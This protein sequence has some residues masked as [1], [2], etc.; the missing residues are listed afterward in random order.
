[1]KRIFF[2][3][4]LMLL[5]VWQAQAQTQVIDLRTGILNGSGTPG[6]KLSH[7]NYTKDDT[8]S[9]CYPGSNP[10]SPSS[11][12]DAYC[13]NGASYYGS[14][15]NT[16]WISPSVDASGTQQNVAAGT[17]HYRT[18]F[19]YN[20]ECNEPLSAKFN[21]RYIGADNEITL[22]MI[23]NGI[24]SYPVSITFNPSATN[25]I[26][27]INPFDIQ[28]GLNEILFAVRNDDLISGM[29][30][31]GELIIQSQPGPLANATFS[32]TLNNGSLQA[33]A[34]Q[35]GTHSWEVFGSPNGNAGTYVYI[36][37]YNTSS[38]SAS[39]YPC[40]KVKHEVETDCGTYCSIQNLCESN[41]NECG[42][43]TEAQ[44]LTY[45]NGTFTWTPVPGAVSY[46]IELIT[47]DPDCCP[48]D[49][50][51]DPVIVNHVFPT[52][53]ASYQLLVDVGS[54][55]SWRVKA[56]CPNGDFSLSVKKCWK[57]GFGFG[58]KETSASGS[59]VRSTDPTSMVQLFPN[60]AKGSVTIEVEGR[61]DE[62]YTINVF[63]MQGKLVKTFGKQK[64]TN[65]K[66]IITWNT[67]LLNKGTYLVKIENF[68][69]PVATKKLVIE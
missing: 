51:E 41:C 39:G 2:G 19:Y 11:Y 55:F 29:D 31:D 32:S 62:I 18:T 13:S 65:K 50:T 23:I 36:G 54:C 7:F 66:A 5:C 64:T 59:G 67:E 47:N 53:T 48:A 34:T 38:I 45:D 24:S 69:K 20:R 14:G 27:P 52:T 61:A 12:V 22:L 25:V 21:F 28:N 57:T 49:P 63:D 30:I 35:T 37:S 3:L 10:L 26:V 15:P 68:G 33:S 42:T 43:L 58:K 60:P 40:Y 9:V 17:Y 4:L 44:N 46:E 56:I 16:K 1:M 8:W 6:T